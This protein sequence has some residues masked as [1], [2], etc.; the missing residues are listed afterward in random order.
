MILYA[1]R[2]KLFPFAKLHLTS[3]CRKAACSYTKTQKLFI[4]CNFTTRK[5]CSFYHK[6]QFF[7]LAKLRPINS[8]CKRAG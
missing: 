5:S 6:K 7:S 2:N 4:E 1:K 8:F 3:F